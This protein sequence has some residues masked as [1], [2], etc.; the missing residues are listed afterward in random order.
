MVTREVTV[1][2]PRPHPRQNEFTRSP[3]KRKVIRA[4]RRGGKTVGVGIL[5]VEQFLRGRRVLY[6]APTTDQV[7]QFWFTV[8]T[9]LFDTIEAGLFT[10]NETEHSIELPNTKQ[11]IRAKTAWN[12]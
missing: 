7:T 4:G 5:A 6:A 9:A 8:T 3:A 11:R 12:A 10:K 2:L 1:S